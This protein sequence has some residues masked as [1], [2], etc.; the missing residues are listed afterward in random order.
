MGNLPRVACGKFHTVAGR[1]QQRGR[2]ITVQQATELR[3]GRVFREER[4]EL[5]IQL[6]FSP[7]VALFYPTDERLL[8]LEI[9]IDL[10][11][12]GSPLNP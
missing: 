11:T 8:L 4:F 9:V 2:L 3:L 6:G 10:I 7:Y 12:R 1:E 5:P